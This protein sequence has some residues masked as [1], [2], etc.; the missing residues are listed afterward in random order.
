MEE[1]GDKF[2]PEDESPADDRVQPDEDAQS[3]DDDLYLD[4]HDSGDK[5]ERGSRYETE[6]STDSDDL[7]Y[8]QKH[9]IG[10]L[11]KVCLSVFVL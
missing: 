7:D 6:A 9:G 8:A 1:K 11:L 2:Q 4:E 3:S 5:T 10:N